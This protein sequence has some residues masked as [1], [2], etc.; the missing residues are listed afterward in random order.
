MQTDQ[1][2]PYF[3]ETGNE[4]ASELLRQD[5]YIKRGGKLSAPQMIKY[6]N[7]VAML[8]ERLVAIHEAVKANHQDLKDYMDCVE[9][10]YAQGALPAQVYARFKDTINP[11]QEKPSYG[12]ER[13]RDRLRVIAGGAQAETSPPLADVT[14]DD[15][16]KMYRENNISRQGLF[17]ELHRREKAGDRLPKM[18]GDLWGKYR[19]WVAERR[20]RKQNNQNPRT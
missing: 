8:V 10:T 18:G 20:R 5:A 17:G 13:E 6:E 19:N 2:L 15:L 3:D 11:D 14:G 12:S 16:L 1:E 7:R 9:Q 4:Y